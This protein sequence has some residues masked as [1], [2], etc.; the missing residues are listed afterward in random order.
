VIFK[1]NK[2]DFLNFPHFFYTNTQRKTCSKSL[3]SQLKNPN[4]KDLFVGWPIEICI[5]P[6]C[7]IQTNPRFLLVLFGLCAMIEMTILYEKQMERIRSD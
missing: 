6:I 2:I 3:M 7:S 1:A 4:V 5:V